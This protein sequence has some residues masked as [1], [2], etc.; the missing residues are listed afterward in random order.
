MIKGITS[1]YYIQKLEW[2]TQIFLEY[3][4]KINSMFISKVYGFII[5]SFQWILKCQRL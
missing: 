5:S 3:V 4:L 1:L 2:H